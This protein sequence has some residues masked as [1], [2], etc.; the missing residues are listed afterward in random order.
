MLRF[1]LATLIN[2]A[3]TWFFVDWS[4]RQAEGQIDKMLDAVFNTPG[5][6]PPI[7]PA[8]LAGGGGLLV[9]QLVLNRLLG[10]RAA[11]SIL[12]ILIGGGLGAAVYVRLKL[13]RAR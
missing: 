11:A 9:A 8:V 10:L 4:G 5:V 13:D 2:T 1:L 6:E 3:I 7:P 12:S